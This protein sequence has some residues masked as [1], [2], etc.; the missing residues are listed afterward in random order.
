MTPELTALTL[1]GL[2]QAVQYTAYSI[3]GQRQLG[4]RVA[5]GTRDNTPELTG[6]TARIHRALNNHFEGLIMFTIAVVV[7]TLSDQSTT[8]TATAAYTYVVARVI[9]VFCYVYGAVPWRSYVWLISMLACITMMI[10]AL[11]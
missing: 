10:A 3:A 11:I 4:Q 2:L 6:K 5:L 8:V 9:Y 7:V 1:A